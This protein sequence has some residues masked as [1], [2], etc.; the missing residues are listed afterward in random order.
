MFEFDSGATGIWDANR[1]N[2]PTSPDA[3]FTFGEAIVEGNGGT[4]RLDGTGRLTLQ[5]LGQ[6]AGEVDYELIKRGFAGDCVYATQQHFVDCLRDGREFE[7][8]GREYLKSLVVVEAIY[9]SAT[10][11][12][13]VRGITEQA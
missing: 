4:L 5:S 12:N 3:R 13:P 6:P 1:Y 9:E 10:T 7:T 8:S 11:G 2:E